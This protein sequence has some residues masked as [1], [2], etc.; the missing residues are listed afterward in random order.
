M[1][2]FG[3]GAFCQH[4][5]WKIHEHLSKIEKKKEP[6][7]PKI[8]K[9]SGLKID[10]KIDAKKG[11]K[12][13]R[14]ELRRDHPEQLQINKIPTEG[15]YINRKKTKRRWPTCKK[16]TEEDNNLHKHQTDD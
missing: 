8:I 10:A 14:A 16:Q 11:A 4:K 6:K 2:F 7:S 12:R 13:W 1:C 3:A 15:T 5:W 9:K